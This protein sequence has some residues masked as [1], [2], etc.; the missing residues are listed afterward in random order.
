MG[1]FTDIGKGGLDTSFILQNM[2][3]PFGGTFNSPEQRDSARQIL[4]Q[5]YWQ[6][7][8]QVEAAKRAADTAAFQQKHASQYN[9][10]PGGGGQIYGGFG[11][12]QFG[13]QSEA[14]ASYRAE[15]DRKRALQD[16]EIQRNLQRQSLEAATS[17]N[18]RF[19]QAFGGDMLGNLM[20]LLMN[21]LQ[22]Q[23]Y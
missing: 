16:A 6:Q 23:P 15:E 20:K 19:N 9:K 4:G 12:Q 22:N 1:Q 8:A 3:S 5:Q 2:L 17:K 21:R 10:G 11:G 18:Q 14:Q 7:Q 13:N